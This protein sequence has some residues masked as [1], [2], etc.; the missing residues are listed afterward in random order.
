MQDGPKCID[1]INETFKEMLRD[2]FSYSNG[3]YHKH[4]KFCVD[5]NDIWFDLNWDVPTRCNLTL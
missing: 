5:A 2:I 1:D 4:M 3:Q